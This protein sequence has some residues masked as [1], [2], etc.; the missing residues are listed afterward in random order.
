MKKWDVSVIGGGLA[1]LA[2]A[3][4]LAREGMD[5]L[6]LEKSDQL[7]GRARTDEQADCLF[8]M[9]PHALYNKGAGSQILNEL[10]VFP[11][12]GTPNPNGVL[13]SEGKLHELPA[14]PLSLIRT[15][16]LTWREKKELV[17]MMF[18]LPKLDVT[19]FYPMS[20]EDWAKEHIAEE[21]VRQ[22]LFTLCRLSSY[23]NEPE[24]AS[25]GVLL[26]Q[27][28]LS[29]AGITYLHGG[30][31]TIVNELRNQAVK[32]GVTIEIHSAVKEITGAARDLLVTLSDGR[33]IASRYVIS[34][35]SP[36]AT[37]RMVK[38][39]DRT[40]LAVWKETVVPVKAACYDLA[41]RK[42]PAPAV[43]F[44]LH[45]EKP[46]YFSNHSKAALLTRDPEHSVV[47]VLKYLDSRQEQNPTQ[48]QQELE[49]FLDQLQPGWRRE[50]IASRFLPSMTVSHGLVTTE[51]GAVL[52]QEGPEVEEIP[53]LYVAGDWLTQNGLL[54]DASLSSARAAAMKILQAKSKREVS[55]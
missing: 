33:T 23:S 8:N 45:L 48:D 46:L 54:A 44:A 27:L 9:G 5:V 31:Q 32:A 1:G 2:S 55:V 40:R 24:R 37:Y 6:L 20:L 18:R 13:I 22:L 15:T 42:L 26:R 4:Y 49:S 30:W 52:E 36:A 3:I 19:A 7:G 47:H 21:R 43:S 41:V 25:A 28:R 50:V 11:K 10:G 51:R 14:A 38:N 16:L 12:G 35:A 34:T 17:R 39:A 53:G 29:A